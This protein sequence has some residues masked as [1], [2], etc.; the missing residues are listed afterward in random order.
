MTDSLVLVVDDDEAMRDALAFQ[1]EAAGYGVCCFAS[2]EELGSSGATRNAACVLADVRLGSGMDGLT[3]LEQLR[4]SGDAVPVVVMT[5]HGDIP[6][7]VRAMRAGAIHFLEKPF[8]P[9]HV[10]EAV[11]E[12]AASRAKHVVAEEERRAARQR[13]ALLTSRER[14]ILVGLGQGK[15][16]KIMAFELGIS[17]RTVEGHRAVLMEKLGVRTLADAIRVSLL[18]ETAA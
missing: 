15:S 16:N 5:G 3:L 17:T 1:L 8:A 14:E 18:A 11:A 2:A 7:A 13:I 4:R 9:E 6:L 12:G 10:L